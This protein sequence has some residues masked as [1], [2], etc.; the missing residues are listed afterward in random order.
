MYAGWVLAVKLERRQSSR[1]FRL[2]LSVERP[3]V[4]GEEPRAVTDPDHADGIGADQLRAQ[5][6]DSENGN[7]RDPKTA[8]LVVGSHSHLL[9][10]TPADL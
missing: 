9:S 4:Q 5:H 1:R 2:E 3:Q 6:D 8:P 7:L 10:C